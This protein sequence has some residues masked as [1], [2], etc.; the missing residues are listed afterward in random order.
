[1][2][3][4]RAMTR[5]DEQAFVDLQIGPIRLN[6]VHLRRDGSIR[7]AQL[8][9]MIGGRRVLIPSIEI[10]DPQLREQLTQA[11][12]T[13][14]EAHLATLPPNERVKAPRLPE[15]RKAGQQPPAVAATSKQPKGPLTVEPTAARGAA[16]TKPTEAGN[17][18]AVEPIH[19]KP[20]AEKPK[21]S[22]P[23]QL[24]AGYPTRT[25]PASGRVRRETK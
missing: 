12:Q 8:T 22:P 23:V 24:L 10:L 5:M 2:L 13:A 11:I 15:E 14:I 7:S 9:P 16:S 18:K 19:A 1:V 6:V 17:T 4:Y 3:A 21:L 20:L 25:A